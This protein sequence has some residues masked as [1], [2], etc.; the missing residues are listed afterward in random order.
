MEWL[1]KAPEHWEALPGRAVFREINDRGN[2]DEQ[3]L[4]VT[5]MRGA[6]RQADLLVDTSKKDSSN[7]DKCDE[8]E[9][10]ICGNHRVYP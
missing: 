4:S 3:M 2:P 7:E 8:T 6:V 1:G 5:I 9:R 10:Y